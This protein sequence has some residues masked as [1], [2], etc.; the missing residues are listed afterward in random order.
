MSAVAVRYAL[1]FLR[2]IILSDLNS[3][4]LSIL[5]QLLDEDCDGITRGTQLETPDGGMRHRGKGL[6]PHSLSSSTFFS[7]FQTNPVGPFQATPC[8][9]CT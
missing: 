5:F 4:S 1:V 9:R 6:C 2:D 7:F 8:H 3:P